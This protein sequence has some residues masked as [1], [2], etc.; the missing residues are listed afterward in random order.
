MDP[1]LLEELEDSGATAEIPER[2]A[3]PP[4]PPPKTQKFKA[5]SSIKTSPDL[6]AK[7][8]AD[9]EFDSIL[10][11]VG[12]SKE[13]P[14]P[15]EQ[16]VAEAEG[17]WGKVWSM[18]NPAVAL[19]GIVKGTG[20]FLANT[21]NVTKEAFETVWNKYSDDKIKLETRQKFQPSTPGQVV[22]MKAAE[23]GTPALLGGVAG[24]VFG[25]VGAIVGGMA[26]SAIGSFIQDPNDT[27]LA[28]AV[29]GT[30]Y[31]NL[32]LL[33]D[34]IDGL[35]HKPGDTDLDKRYKNMLEDIYL[36]GVLG[37][38]G[39]TVG[40]IGSRAIR[41]TGQALKT[42]KDDFKAYRYSKMTPVQ[43]AQE[44]AIEARRQAVSAGEQQAEQFRKQAPAQ[45]QKVEELQ[46][47]TVTPSITEEELVAKEMQYGQ[48]G[49]EEGDA[50]VKKIQELPDDPAAQ[51]AAKTPEQI[52][53]ELEDAVKLKQEAQQLDMFNTRPK[54]EQLSFMDMDDTS[55]VG[56]KYNEEVGQ[57]FSKV[58]DEAMPEQLPLG[59]VE[60]V[61]LTDDSVVEALDV[62]AAKAAE[63]P[64]GYYYNQRAAEL[65][66]DYIKVMEEAAERNLDPAEKAKFLSDPKYRDP[67]TPP[68]DPVEYEQVHQLHMDA[69]VEFEALLAKVSSGTANDAE[70][71]AY[72]LAKKNV[73]ILG[74][75]D[76]GTG[77]TTAHSLGI[78]GVIKKFSEAGDPVAQE[79][80]GLEGKAK[81]I[82]KVIESAGGKKT[83][84]EEATLFAEFIEQAQRPPGTRNS[85]NGLPREVVEEA[86]NR[87][88]K[89][90]KSKYNEY[91][92]DAM[93][94]VHVKSRGRTLVESIT[95]YMMDNMVNSFATVAQT[96]SVA[97]DMA[98]NA[99]SAYTHALLTLPKGRSIETAAK[100]AKANY[101]ATTMAYETKNGIALAL[102]EFTTPSVRPGDIII[103]GASEMTPSYLKNHVLKN[104]PKVSQLAAQEKDAIRSILTG[105]RVYTLQL[106]RKLLMSADAMTSHI[107]YSAS[108]KSDLAMLG[109]SQGLKG[110]ELKEFVETNFRK[111]PPDLHDRALHEAA[112]FSYRADLEIGWLN[113]LEGALNK[114]PM[115]KLFMPF[116]RTYGNTVERALEYFPGLNL[117]L[118]SQRDQFLA[119]RFEGEGAITRIVEG[120]TSE[121][122]AKQLTGLGAGL[123]LASRFLDGSITM[124]DAAG[125]YKYKGLIESDGLGNPT[126]VMPLSVKTKDGYVQL[127]KG[128]ALEKFIK[129]WGYLALASNHFDQDEL[130]ASGF[131]AAT[132]LSQI[133]SINEQ[134]RTVNDIQDILEDVGNKNSDK[135]FE[136]FVKLN[137]DL[138]ERMIPMYRMGKDF[139]TQ[140]ETA[141]LTNTFGGQT[142]W[143]YVADTLENRIKKIVPGMS[144]DVPPQ[145]NALGE[146]VPAFK[147]N[148]V[149]IPGFMLTTSN[150][151]SEVMD[152]LVFLAEYSQRYR[153]GEVE[154]FSLRPLPK[155]LDIQGIKVKL[156]SQQYAKYNEFYGGYDRD[157]GQLV[158]ITED[159]RKILGVGL[160][161]RDALDATIKEIRNEYKQIETRTV[162]PDEF[163][164]QVAARINRVIT[165]YRDQAKKLMANEPDIIEAINKQT[166]QKSGRLPA[167]GTVR[168]MEQTLRGR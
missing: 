24:S 56:I 116:F 80:I 161:L 159:G 86:A 106:G 151:S 23:I 67:V 25:P 59:K 98:L 79:L 108:L 32:P 164:E 153:E 122:S 88:Q 140:N 66:V 61:T 133:L 114:H 18:A 41:R 130:D 109:R 73:G 38:A 146:P 119:R 99:M 162:S 104:S 91:Y 134:F 21:S 117:S 48:V 154:T 69:L 44:Q 101:Y 40:T 52:V 42:V 160:S 68:M 142:G 74:N 72:E 132:A 102:K 20:Q 150:K 6:T 7:A 120:V 126:G 127:P 55:V 28:T 47:Q 53:A 17:F 107:G 1:F 118:K 92:M 131:A 105:V 54:E 82:R 60:K 141:V 13:E 166:E 9:S 75:I 4:P 167:P 111:P 157:S 145:F 155:T 128:G 149:G 43:Q 12:V 76:K 70:L 5:S 3:P 15:I 129:V 110:K 57:Q 84:Q 14:K 45:E 50:L 89:I 33:A 165:V 46:K 8:Q 83:L 100:L 93:G 136:A 10:E 39:K 156:N 22:S 97:F 163:N 113:T 85:I 26:G 63:K 65:P 148:A 31:A 19:P 36:G 81:A 152:Y 62:V 135:V 58:F 143:D 123:Y 78:R 71:A 138:A 64:R 112:K 87:I 168:F 94:E 77:T 137:A 37:A 147:S 121:S 124:P 29:Q 125:G 139:N 144:A 51:K 49:V 35:A 90:R 103:S 30:K 27:N 115:A 16:E 11:S 34:T 158:S 95:S 2:A 96:S